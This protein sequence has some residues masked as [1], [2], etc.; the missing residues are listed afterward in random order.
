MPLPAALAPLRH[1][2]FLLLSTGSALTFLGA[3]IQAVAAAWEMMSL[4]PSST[5]VA[6]VQTATTLPALIF[7]L[8]GGALADMFDRRR[9]LMAAQGIMLAAACLLLAFQQGGLMTPWLLLGLTFL[10]NIGSTLRA[11]VQSA[12]AND[13]VDR[14][15]V[16]A[17][18][19]ITGIGA[20]LAR[21]I[22]PGLGGA[23][24]ATC[25]AIGAFV[26]NALCICGAIGS[27]LS[28]RTTRTSPEKRQRHVGHAILEG[29]RYCAADRSILRLQIRIFCWVFCAVAIWALL[30]L[31]AKRNLGGGPLSLG[32]L[33]ACQG[34]GAIVG[35]ALT[36]GW[37]R[38]QGMDKLLRR[39]TLVFVTVLAVSAFANH[40]SWLAP[41]L[42]VGGGAWLSFLS[43]PS[44]AIQMVAPAL[45]RG[46][47][48]SVNVMSLYA[49]MGLGAWCWGMLADAAGLRAALIVAAAG[50]MANLLLGRRLPHAESTANPSLSP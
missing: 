35:A 11:P 29:L 10:L 38:N 24:I 27:S 21:S 9:V 3:N 30:P 7:A 33:L 46:R 13:I 17:A 26:A 18:V 5:L 15:E 20:N 40:P 41:T 42:V 23:L 31:I 25:G 32:I 47:V 8:V 19:A 28:L 39:L 49:A 44:S 16:P 48:L 50:M 37:L 4:T 14:A 1:R 45:V 43:A 22:G 34:V 6:L 36:P 2:S 12:L